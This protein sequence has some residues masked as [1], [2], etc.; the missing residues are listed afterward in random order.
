[1]HEPRK[2]LG[3]LKTDYWSVGRI[4]LG[5]SEM[6]IWHVQHH[7]VICLACWMNVLSQHFP[8]LRTADTTDNSVV[9]GACLPYTHQKCLWTL[10]TDFNSIYHST[11]CFLLWWWYHNWLTVLSCP[12]IAK[13][14]ALLWRT[15]MYTKA[16]SNLDISSAKKIWMNTTPTFFLCASNN[17]RCATYSKTSI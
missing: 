16:I 11:L 6:I 12:F 17:G 10:T 3:M 1:M 14:R 4:L 13:Y 15:C 7:L 8:Y 2:I 5:C 9:I